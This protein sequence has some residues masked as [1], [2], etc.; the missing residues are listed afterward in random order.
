LVWEDNLDGSWSAVTDDANAD[1]VLTVDV[2]ADGTYT[3]TMDAVI[4]LDG[5]FTSFTLDF[6]QG[7][8]GGNNEQLV[9]FDSAADDLDPVDNIPDGSSIMALA[10]GTDSDGTTGTVNSSNQGMGVS[11]GNTIDVNGGLS[12][13][14]SLFFADPQDP[15]TIAGPGSLTVREQSF[16]TI[17]LDSLNGGEFAIIAVHIA[18]TDEDIYFKVQ[19]F[20]SGASTDEVVTIT[21]GTDGDGS[22]SGDGLS[23]ATTFEVDMSVDG[24]GTLFVD[25]TFDHL[26]FEADVAT[27]SSYR[28]VSASGTEETSGFDVDTSFTATSTDGDGDTVDTEFDVSL[29]SGTEMNGTAGDDVL[30]GNGGQTIDQVINGL[31]GSDI[32]DGGAGSDTIDGGSGM[33]SFVYNSGSDTLNDIDTIL[34]F[35]NAEDSFD[36]S[37]LTGDIGDVTFTTS[38]DGDIVVNINGSSAAELDGTSGFTTVDVAVGSTVDEVALTIV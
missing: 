5:A 30:I 4:P 32:I 21:Q 2:N 22:L 3:V 14:L 17:R 35:N 23:A 34:N 38:G 18:G 27:D 25:G 16:A 26:H 1:V 31:G 28:L 15:S 20:G 11:Q 8:T 12:E 7:V 10:V 29:D 33:D 6:T 24:F 19:G 36:F 13:E 9:F 37:A